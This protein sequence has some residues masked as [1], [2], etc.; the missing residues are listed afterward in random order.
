MSETLEQ[1]LERKHD[2]KWKPKKLSKTRL[3]LK[4]SNISEDARTFEYSFGFDYRT[5]KEP[6]SLSEWL[7][8]KAGQ[9]PVKPFKLP[10]PS[11][12]TVTKAHLR[13]AQGDVERVQSQYP[14][15]YRQ[16]SE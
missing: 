12:L 16:F 7:E 8:R 1:F 3:T 15:Y 5:I 11:K 6:L 2:P 13:Q 9:N 4:K 14:E 10:K